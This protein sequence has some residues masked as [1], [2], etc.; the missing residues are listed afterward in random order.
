MLTVYRIFVCPVR[1]MEQEATTTDTHTHTTKKMV[2]TVSDW[3][4]NLME[5]GVVF[6]SS[7]R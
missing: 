4:G 1:E 2:R 7:R 6:F 5:A 3:T